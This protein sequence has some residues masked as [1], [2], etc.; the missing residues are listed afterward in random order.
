MSSTGLKRV[1]ENFYTKKEIAETC[2]NKLKNENIIDKNDL[3]IEPSAGDGAFIEIIKTFSKEYKFYDISPKHEEVV[4]QDFLQLEIERDEKIHFVGNPPFGRQSSLAKKFIKKCCL[5]GDSISFI[6]PKSFKKESFQKSFSL[7][8]H[9]IYQYDLPKYSFIINGKDH[10]VP[11]V[12][13]IWKRENY[14]RQVSEKEDPKNFKFVKKEESHDISVRRVGV[15][16]GEVNTETR[17]KSVT[18]HY[19]IKFLKPVDNLERFKSIKF[20]SDNTVGPKSISKPELIKE[21]NMLIL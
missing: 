13:Q 14:N 6:L 20:P 1:N 8:F 10:D 17:D 16:A 15:Y 3:I 21:F 7:D 11:C 4:E 2:F 12:F 9:L 5:V 19:F 18:S